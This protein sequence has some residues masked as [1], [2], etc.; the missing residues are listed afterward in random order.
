MGRYA[1]LA[2]GRTTLNIDPALKKRAT[3]FA[4]RH[5]LTLS[6]LIEHGLKLAMAQKEASK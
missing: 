1:K 6:A 5:G 3:L 4:L 2:S